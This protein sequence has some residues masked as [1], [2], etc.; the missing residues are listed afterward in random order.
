MAFKLNAAKSSTQGSLLFVLV[1]ALT[2]VA[3][4]ERSFDSRAAR[5]Q[6]DHE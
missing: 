5:K 4:V 3:A 1:W 2:A 6:L